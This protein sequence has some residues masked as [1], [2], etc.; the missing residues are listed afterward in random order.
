MKTLECQTKK[1]DLC[2]TGMR[3]MGVINALCVVQ[4]SEESS[5]LRRF[6]WHGLHG[7]QGKLKR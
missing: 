2:S 7:E 3:A 6:L 4:E 1:Y 5:V